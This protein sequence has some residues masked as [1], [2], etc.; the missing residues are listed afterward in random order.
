M[1]QSPVF[2]ILATIALIALAPPIGRIVQTAC[3]GSWDLEV[4]RPATAR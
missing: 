3:A 1:T 2:V 4:A